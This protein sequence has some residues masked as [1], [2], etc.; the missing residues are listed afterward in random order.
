[1][2]R[3]KGDAGSLVILDL[4][5]GVNVMIA[6]STFTSEGCGTDPMMAPEVW[7][8]DGLRKTNKVDVFSSAM[9]LLEYVFGSDAFSLLSQCKERDGNTGALFTPEKLRGLLKKH[10][11]KFWKVPSSDEMIDLL[12]G[13]TKTNPDERL[14]AEEWLNHQALSSVPDPLEEGEDVPTSDPQDN[15]DL[16]SA[17]Q[18]A[19]DAKEKAAVLKAENDE[20][21][22]KIAFYQERHNNHDGDVVTKIA[23]LEA[24]NTMLEKNLLMA[25]EETAKEKETATKLQAECD[26]LKKRLDTGVMGLDTQLAEMSLKPA[27]KEGAD[28]LETMRSS[29]EAKSTKLEEA[30]TQ[31][32]TLRQQ[33]QQA[34][35]VQANGGNIV[36]NGNG[37][38]A[39]AKKFL[40][41]VFNG[42][43][44]EHEASAR[45]TIINAVPADMSDADRKAELKR[46]LEAAIDDGAYA[47]GH[48]AVAEAI[49]LLEEMGCSITASQANQFYTG[50]HGA[51]APM[52]LALLTEDA[53]VSESIRD[54]GGNNKGALDRHGYSA[55]ITRQSHIDHIK[56]ALR[57]YHQTWQ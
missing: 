57:N 5:L 44:M 20:L 42:V 34:Q 47:D 8:C 17:I 51:N 10:F 3:E 52:S 32:A 2:L 38:V 11:D 21:K 56:T 27:A 50:H 7:L 48:A 55:G 22:T 29:L 9:T 4:G 25:N 28:D 39:R 12:L 53:I 49:A 16:E 15:E 31:I 46:N 40:R 19:A 41:C 26:D 33:L 35:L 54:T 30:Q 37:L 24:K 13:M 1:M 14:S 43:R 6:K 45:A 18:R 23:D 36:A